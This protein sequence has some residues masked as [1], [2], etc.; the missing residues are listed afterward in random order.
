[1]DR[2]YGVKVGGERLLSKSWWKEVVE[3]FCAE[4][5]RKVVDGVGG[6]SW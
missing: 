2:D 3:G 5:C 1:M 6:I 4:N